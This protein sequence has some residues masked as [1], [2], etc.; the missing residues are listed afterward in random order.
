MSP[1]SP[2]FL[3]DVA[4]RLAQDGLLVMSTPKPHGGLRACCWSAQ[5]RRSAIVPKGTHHWQGFSSRPKN[6]KSLLADAGADCHGEARDRVAAGQGVAP[7][8]RHGAELYPE[9]AAG[10]ITRPGAPLR[11]RSPIAS[12][13][14]NTPETPAFSE[15]SQPACSPRTL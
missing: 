4:A 9:R 2:A 12:P 11:K 8:G 6:W 10:L 13:S 7:V 14:V 3:R 15:Q 5:R 1:T